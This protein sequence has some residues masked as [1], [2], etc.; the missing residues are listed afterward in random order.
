MPALR[1]AIVGLIENDE[2][3]NFYV[4]NQGNFDRMVRN[5]L[6]ELS[7]KYKINYTVVLAYFPKEKDNKLSALTVMPDGIERV[8]PRFAISYRNKWMLNKADYV[9]TYVTYSWG[10]AAKFKE[11]AKKKNKKVINI[12]NL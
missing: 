4:G 6:E 11:M 8:H 10:G 1:D 9:V 5:A 3:R 2:V 7:C 12:T